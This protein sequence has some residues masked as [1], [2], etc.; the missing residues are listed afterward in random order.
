MKHKSL[1][2]GALSILLMGSG[3]GVVSASASNTGDTGWSNQYRVKSTRDHTPARK[4]TNRSAYYNYTKKAS[5]AVRYINIHAALYDGRDV[6]G[7]HE[8][9]SYV[10]S[11]TKLWNNAVETHGNGVAVRIDSIRKA[12]GSASGVWSPDS[13]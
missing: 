9:K 11:T 13:K 8:Y 6:S 7:G 12:N 3:M 1:A 10:G 5:K 2:I 4:K